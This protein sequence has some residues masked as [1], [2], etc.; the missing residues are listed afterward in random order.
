MLMKLKRKL[1]LSFT[2]TFIVTSVLLLVDIGL[3]VFFA[4]YSFQSTTGIIRGK[5]MEAAYTAASLL[6]ENEVGEL[7]LED[8]ANNTERYQKAYNV[9]YS[10]KTS[11]EDANGELAYIYLLVQKG[12][13]IVFSI[14][15]SDDP[16]EFLVEEPIYTEAMR[17]AFLGN[18]GTDDQPYTDR[19]GTLYSGYAPVMK[20]NEVVAVVGV[21]VWADYVNKEVKTNVI[22]ISA[23][24]ATTIGLG[25][26][27]SLLI[28]FAMRHR[29]D[30]VSHNLVALEKDIQGLVGAIEAP[31]NADENFE[32]E[33]VVKEDSTDPLENI[34]NKLS[35]LHDEI[36][37]YIAY[38]EEQASIDRL[39]K[40]ENRNAYSKITNL[41]NSEIEKGELKELVVAIYDVNGLKII[42]D[43][44][45][46]DIGDKLLKISAKVIQVVYGVD[47]CFR[48]GGDEF[49]IV[50][51][52]NEEDF[53]AKNE[54]CMALLDQFNQNNTELPFSISLSVGYSLFDVGQDQ[55]L[56]DVFRKADKHMYEQKNAF[57]R[58]LRKKQ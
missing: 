4:I 5:I 20:G 12:D 17:S 32:P 49:V 25:V 35:I 11:S 7:T 26:G 37:K 47:N 46:H 52:G 28:T 40:L 43:E 16:G 57:Y 38:A 6:D 22:A 58:N 55:N 54:E 56:L 36:T 42:N 50:L 2:I 18:A 48:I 29:V 19:W 14:D 10:F 27:L 23:V 39:T 3:N 15:P 51:R 34:R 33:I 31:L 44:H 30:E 21:D 1:P 24:A 45:G 13:K 53:K 8:K 41:I 9:L